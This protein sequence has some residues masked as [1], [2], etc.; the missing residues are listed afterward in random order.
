MSTAQQTIWSMMITDSL[1]VADWHLFIPEVKYGV[2]KD[3]AKREEKARD[4]ES[5]WAELA[6]QHCLLAAPMKALVLVSSAAGCSVETVVFDHD[7]PLRTLAQLA[8]QDEAPV[9]Q[10]HQQED[11]PGHL[12]GVQGSAE[13]LH[14]NA[15]RGPRAD[16]SAGAHAG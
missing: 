15:P 2:L 4:H 11:Q 10:R 6:T 14:L 8:A 9:A 13:Q 12:F 16:R 1:A 7:K 3:P 5:R